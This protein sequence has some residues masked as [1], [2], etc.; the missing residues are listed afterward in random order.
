MGMVSDTRHVSVTC[1]HVIYTCFLTSE[2]IEL[3]TSVRGLN[4][5]EFHQES[6]GHGLRHVTRVRLV[7]T[8]D[9]HVIF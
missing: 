3:Q 8:R 5:V 7:S 9:L 6:N 1:R 2:P 4:G